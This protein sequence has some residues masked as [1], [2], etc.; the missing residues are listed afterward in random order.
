MGRIVHAWVAV[1]DEVLISRYQNTC[2]SWQWTNGFHKDLTVKLLPLHLLITR[3]NIYPVNSLPLFIFTY[4][5][6]SLTQAALDRGPSSRPN[7]SVALLYCLFPHIFMLPPTVFTSLLFLCSTDTHAV[8]YWWKIR[9]TGLRVE[10]ETSGHRIF[11]SSTMESS[12]S[13]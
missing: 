1:E 5:F 6:S 3:K 4:Y 7:S 11:T 8:P 10:K 2:H 13:M 9:R 12:S